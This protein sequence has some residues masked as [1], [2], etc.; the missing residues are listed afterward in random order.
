MC[1]PSGCPLLHR[2]CVEHHLGFKAA[3]NGRTGNLLVHGI[4]CVALGGAAPRGNEVSQ[5]LAVVI[6]VYQSQGIVGVEV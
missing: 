5:C 4:R 3:C 6:V 1:E 2:K